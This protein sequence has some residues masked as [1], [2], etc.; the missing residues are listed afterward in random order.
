LK[1]GVADFVF[2][3]PLDVGAD[4]I[5]EIVGVE[6]GGREGGGRRCRLGG[7]GGEGEGWGGRGGDGRW[8]GGCG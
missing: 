4:G 2:G 6:V 7:G 1:V 5:R 3:Q 8:E